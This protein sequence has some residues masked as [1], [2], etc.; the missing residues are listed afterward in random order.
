MHTGLTMECTGAYFYYN[1]LGNE[2]QR[3]KLSDFLRLCKYS[4]L[5]MC[6]NDLEEVPHQRKTNNYRTANSNC[7]AQIVIFPI[8]ILKLYEIE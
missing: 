7:I 2:P 5:K 1:L 4:L 6:A 3:L 8:K